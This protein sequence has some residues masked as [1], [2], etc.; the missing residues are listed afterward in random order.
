VLEA[1]TLP[2]GEFRITM[3]SGDVLRIVAADC[4]FENGPTAS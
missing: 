3:Q 1:S 4:T 2:G